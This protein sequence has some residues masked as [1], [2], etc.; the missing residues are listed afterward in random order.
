[1]NSKST[2]YIFN[3]I[4][5]DTILNSLIKFFPINSPFNLYVISQESKIEYE[6]FIIDGL[7]NVEQTY[8]DITNN[9]IY[10]DF[11]MLNDFYNIV[12]TN[13]GRELVKYGG[14]KEFVKNACLKQ[15]AESRGFWIKKNWFWVELLK[16]VLSVVVGV[17]LTL[18]V[19]YLR[20]IKGQN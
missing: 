2:S 5:L 7:S 9:L 18:G 16:V 3:S 1:M 12:L 10:N 6:D 15:D 20:G 11:A 4:E 17:L 8:I 14:Y 13:K 19:Q